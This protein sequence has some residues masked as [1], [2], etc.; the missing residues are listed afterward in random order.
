VPAGNFQALFVGKVTSPWDMDAVALRGNDLE[1]MIQIASRHSVIRFAS[2]V[3]GA[4][5][6]PVQG[7]GGPDVGLA[8][9]STGATKYTWNVNPSGAPQTQLVGWGGATML[10]LGADKVYALSASGTQILV[11][12]TAGGTL[13]GQTPL[14]LNGTVRDWPLKWTATNEALAILYTSSLD[15][16]DAS[17]NTQLWSYPAF[18]DTDK[19]AVSHG[20]GTERDY[21]LWGLD[22]SGA[23]YVATLNSD[24][25]PGPSQ[26]PLMT[27][28]NLAG[29]ITSFEFDS[30]DVQGG[31]TR[32]DLIISDASTADV[33]VLERQDPNQSTYPFWAP[34]RFVLGSLNSAP[35]TLAAGGDVDG[36]GD[37]DALFGLN[38]Q[39]EL[40]VCLNGRIE[41]HAIA[42]KLGDP[43][44][45]VLPVTANWSTSFVTLHLL[46]GPESIGGTSVEIEARNQFD[47][48]SPATL[49]SRTTAAFPGDVPLHVTQEDF[50]DLQF[51]VREVKVVG[52]ITTK[53]P[54]K[55]YAYCIDDDSFHSL[56]DS[57]ET[58]QYFDWSG[59]WGNYSTVIGKPPGGVTPIGR[60][61]GGP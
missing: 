29:A 34:S 55:T 23:T 11:A 54:T 26:F 6:L 13:T 39:N 33:Y 44:N 50:I 61:T 49:I 10:R 52:G 45:G 47:L 25:L 27:L 36:D 2:G 30:A 12:S 38:G 14:T 8:T 18:S 37:Q 24:H 9:N 59:G 4:V 5:L 46:R 35:A 40:R 31:P 53:S 22:V 19:I 48:G 3:T 56:S 20:H 41:R 28:G 7:T 57:P 51:I 58:Q 17:Q 15:V 43:E 60:G 21:L 42:P 1:L 32:E 16:R